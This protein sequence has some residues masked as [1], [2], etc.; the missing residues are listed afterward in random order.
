MD[1]DQ[2]KGLKQR[3]FKRKKC[4]LNSS[5]ERDPRDEEGVSGSLLMSV[6]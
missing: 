6:L 4:V 5:D 3:I 1:Y 2:M